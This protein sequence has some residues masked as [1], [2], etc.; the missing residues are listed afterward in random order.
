MGR[1]RA[2]PLAFHPFVRGDPGY[3]SYSLEIREQGAPFFFYRQ[4]IIETGLQTKFAR[5]SQPKT[6]RE[7]L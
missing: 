3:P 5:R 1:A 7:E 2:T 6:R 4:E